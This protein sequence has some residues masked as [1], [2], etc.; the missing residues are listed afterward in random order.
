MAVAASSSS[1]LVDRMLRAARLDSSL[2]DEVDADSSAT[3]QWDLSLSLPSKLRTRGSNA[4]PAM[5]AREQRRISGQNST[6]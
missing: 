6:G 5:S 1:S 3:S 2:Y 4:G